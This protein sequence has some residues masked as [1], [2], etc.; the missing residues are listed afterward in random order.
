[1]ILSYVDDNYIIYDKSNTLNSDDCHVVKVPNV[2]YNIYDELHFIISHYNKLPELIVFVKGNFWKHCK[3]ETFDKIIMNEC[4]TPIEDY[5]YYPEYFAHKKD[6]D[7]GYMEK[8]DSW[9]LLPNNSLTHK[10]VDTYNQFLDEA[11]EDPIYPEFVRFAPGGQYI[12]P[13]KNILYYSKDFYKRLIELVD[14][15]QLPAEAHLLERAMYTIYTNKFK[16]KRIE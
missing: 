3:V 16:E 10:Y 1:L 11:F 9:Y 15:G 13:K 8:N 14:Y 6:A 2:G 12:V 5:S 4:F 7:G